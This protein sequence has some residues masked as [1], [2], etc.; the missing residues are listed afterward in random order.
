[1]TL[2]EGSKL[3][4]TQHILVRRGH[5][6]IIVIHVNLTDARVV[7]EHATGLWRLVDNIA[8]WRRLIS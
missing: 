4:P 3:H 6:D 8:S 1:M 5:M 2:I 7:F